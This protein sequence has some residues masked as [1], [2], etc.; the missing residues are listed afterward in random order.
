ML[1]NRNSLLVCIFKLLRIKLFEIPNLM[2]I[3]NSQEESSNSSATGDFV[4]LN[5]STGKSVITNWFN[6]CIT[7]KYLS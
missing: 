4:F 7:V 1:L 5:T 6:L 2:F 3:D